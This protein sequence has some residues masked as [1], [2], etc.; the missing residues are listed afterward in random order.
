MG[1]ANEPNKTRVPE[2][3]EASVPV[4]G[5]T[6]N[7]TPG[8]GPSPFPLMVTISPGAIAPAAPLA[9]FVT[10]EI[11]TVEVAV[12]TVKVTRMVCGLFDAPGAVTVTVPVY[13]VGFK[14][15][16][17]TDTMRVAPEVDR[18]SHEALEAVVHESAPPPPLLM[19]MLCDGGLAP[20]TA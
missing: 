3:V 11:T 18:L 4:L 14:D 9:E 13:V 19:M 2:R 5:S 12:L 20:P 6:E 10:D 1:A 17:F 8:V 15:R 7:C 16:G